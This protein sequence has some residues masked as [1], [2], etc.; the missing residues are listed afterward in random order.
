VQRATLA[1]SF[2]ARA[3]LRNGIVARPGEFIGEFLN[4]IQTD[5]EAGIINRVAHRAILWNPLVAV[6][7]NNGRG[8]RKG[9]PNQR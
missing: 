8:R 2:S 5:G 1:V 6:S 9:P 7:N 3:L 4:P